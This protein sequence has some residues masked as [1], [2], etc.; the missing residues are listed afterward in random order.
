MAIYHFSGQIISRSTGRSVVAAAAY[1]AADHLMDERT[2]Q[3]RDYTH[4]ADVAHTEIMLPAGAPDWMADREKLWNAVEAV[5][6]R[7]DAQL[8]REFNVSL[9]R[10]LTK[11]QNIV[12]AREF[13]QREFVA[14][15]MVA[16][17]A[18][19][20]DQGKD[21]EAQPH[22]HVLLT[23]REVTPEGF[24]QKVR[25]WNDKSLLLG[26]REAWAEVANRHLAFY[27]HDI[28]IDHRTLVEQG[29]DLSPQS[30]IGP[31]SAQSRLARMAEHEQKARENGEKILENPLIAL[32]ALTQQHS[33]FTHHDIAR[34]ASRNSVEV[35]QFNQVMAVVKAHPELVSLGQDDL[36]RERWTTQSMLTLEKEM[37][38]QAIELSASERHQVSERRLS[39]VKT[40]GT[41]TS[42]QAAAFA[43]L[44]EAGSLRCVVGFAGTGKSYLLGA[45]REAWEAQGYRVLGATLAG[46]AAEGLEAG[47]G[48]ESRTLHSRRYSWA[49]GH[50]RLTAKDVLVVDEAGMLGSQQMA[51]LVNEVHEKGA[52]LVLVGDPE[53]L[54]AIQAGAA[55]RAILERV[56]FVELTEIR[57]QR[58]DWQKAATK[59]LAVGQTREALAAY[60]AHGMVKGFATQ[61]EAQ[62]ALIA[63]WDTVCQAEPDKTQLILAYT[64]AEVQ[65]LNEQA[66]YCR[67]ER[68]ELGQ[69][70]VLMTDRGQRAFAEQDRIYFLKNDRLLGVKNGSLGTIEQ[71]LPGETLAVRLDKLDQQGKPERVFFQLSDYNHIDH[72][73]AA[74]LYK[75]QSV[76]VDRAY[77]LASSYLDRQSAYVGLSRHREEV[78]LY[79]SREQFDDKKAL[80]KIL[81]RDR[82]KDTS[83]DYELNRSAEGW[84]MTREFEPVALAPPLHAPEPSLPRSKELLSAAEMNQAI[85]AFLQKQNWSPEQT[86]RSDLD[87]RRLTPLSPSDHLAAFKAQ[88][89]TEH[90][91]RAQALNEALL[92]RHERLALE[93]VRDFEPLERSLENSLTPRTVQSQLEWQA[94]KVSKQSEVMS[95]LHEHHPDL[96]EKIGGWAKTHSAHQP[97]QRQLEKERDLGEIEL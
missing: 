21:G 67:Q 57:R 93:T 3:V 50:D 18:L 8:A 52:K 62:K 33:T 40:V 39:K 45:A 80:D 70:Q 11:E 32:N 27:D 84:T 78:G 76:T 96:S 77:V 43:H 7:K 15:G 58:E 51:E 10:E 47:S 72:G 97:P 49:Q 73:Y 25:A 19:H 4:K 24:G 71:I 23:M 38:T 56:G 26:W 61:A 16:D 92:P 6:K 75:A 74:T 88:F 90:P 87:H 20:N 29:I 65:A 30:K 85:D 31:V 89:E 94:D 42:E 55:F 81:S 12:L 34:F 69:E 28:R 59:A 86:G 91:E 95:Y 1:R 66:R 60:E 5:E 41:L 54:Q 36:G 48:I 46:K 63:G 79:W 9:P 2:D 82:G 44:T 83:L 13:I 14:K 64:R 68:G 37:I 22:T 17:F 53:Q 35:E